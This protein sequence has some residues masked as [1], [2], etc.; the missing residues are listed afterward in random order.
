L[1][2]SLSITG[3]VLPTVAL[4]L[5][6]HLATLSLETRI[7]LGAVLKDDQ[8]NIAIINHY[9]SPP[10]FTQLKRPYCSSEPGQ[11]HL[12]FCGSRPDDAVSVYNPVAGVESI[13]MA[14]HS[15]VDTLCVELNTPANVTNV[16]NRTHLMTR[17]LFAK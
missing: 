4:Q 8:S 5:L 14:G 3:P 11:Q 7:F 9:Q 2:K 12:W 16:P 17:P 6:Q 13:A 1:T 10:I 15:G